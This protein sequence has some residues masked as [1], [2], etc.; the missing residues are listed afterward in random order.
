MEEKENIKP[1][2][3]SFL[4]KHKRFIW[5]LCDRYAGGNPDTGLDHVQ[6]ISILLWLRY[7]KLR[8]DSTPGQQRKWISYI[9][10]DYFRGLSKRK[11]VPVELYDD[12]NRFAIIPVDTDDLHE[13]LEEYRECLSPSEKRVV[14]LYIEGF[15]ANDIAAIIGAD[16][17]AVRQQFHRI[18]VH[19]REYARKIEKK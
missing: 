10:R 13:R 15:K 17:A 2:F 8:H 14:D 3:I 16:A 11:T 6:E 5:K 18:T 4:A 19:M 12:D 9:A 7:G 1:D